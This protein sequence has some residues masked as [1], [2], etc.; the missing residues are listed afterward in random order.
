MVH[1]DSLLRMYESA[2]GYWNA[3]KLMGANLRDFGDAQS[4]VGVL[5]FEVL[6]KC[7][8]RIELGK[9]PSFGHDYNKGWTDLPETKRQKILISAQNRYG[10]HADF[11]SIDAVMRDFRTTFLKARYSYEANESLSNFEIAQKGKAWVDA[12]A[13]S[14]EADF[15]F[16]PS[17]LSALV[18]ALS[19]HIQEHLM[20]PEEDVLRDLD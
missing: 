11:S 2:M 12:G 16:R 8:Y 3:R 20:L 9:R 14:N 1:T 5:A 10:S 7:V 6:L 18:F 4:V 13:P 17:E 15:R 19:S